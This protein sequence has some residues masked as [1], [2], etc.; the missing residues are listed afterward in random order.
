MDELDRAMQL[1]KEQS[2]RK[3][4]EK[5]VRGRSSM[6]HPFCMSLIC[7]VVC[8]HHL[9]APCAPCQEEKEK[10]A[11]KEEETE[12]ADPNGWTTEEL[13]ALATITV[14]V[15]HRKAPE[16][17]ASSAVA[18]PSKFA[19]GGPPVVLSDEEEATVVEAKAKLGRWADDLKGV[20]NA[21]DAVLVGWLLHSTPEV[22]VS[23]YPLALHTVK[24]SLLRRF[25][26]DAPPP[27]PPAKRPRVSL[28]ASKKSQVRSTEP[29][30]ALGYHPRPKGAPPCN[31]QGTKVI[32]SY[33]RGIWVDGEFPGTWKGVAAIKGE[34]NVVDAETVELDQRLAALNAGVDEDKIKASSLYHVKVMTEEIEAAQ[35]AE[36]DRAVTEAEAEAKREHKRIVKAF[37]EKIEPLEVMDKL[38][39]KLEAR[40]PLPLKEPEAWEATIQEGAKKGYATL[41]ARRKDDK[42]K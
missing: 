26:G 41:A 36:A 11:E 29:V 17:I 7:P 18:P 38:L 2:K 25:G 42:V 9:S 23:Y 15:G 21:C 10:E 22:R 14:T 32:W 16:R 20:K 34:E 6:P 31:D 35:K 37:E 30:Q 28:P 33:K 13:S 27:A 4:E 24:D 1:G 19:D 39:P 12:P 40:I 5:E 3:R 8:P